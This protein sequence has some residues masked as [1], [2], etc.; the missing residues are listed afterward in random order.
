M[1]AS[2][3]AFDFESTINIISLIIRIYRILLAKS[4]YISTKLAKSGLHQ[5][6]LTLF[7][8][9]FADNQNFKTWSGCFWFYFNFA[10]IFAAILTPVDILI[11][12]RK[13]KVIMG[14]LFE[15]EFRKIRG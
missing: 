9:N 11:F 10:K 13:V 8:I 1:K 6:N 12:S 5:L 3:N 7:R 4:D 15:L 14:G 2:K